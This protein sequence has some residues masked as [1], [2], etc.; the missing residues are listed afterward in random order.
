MAIQ[1]VSLAFLTNEQQEQELI[2]IF[3]CVKNAILAIKDQDL[4][5]R[6][7]E[8]EAKTL[9]IYSMENN[10]W[11]DLDDATLEFTTLNKE[12]RDKLFN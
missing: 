1:K 5:M 3:S 4:L 2:G 10:S 11:F 9:E 8:Y 12:D 7:I 6:G